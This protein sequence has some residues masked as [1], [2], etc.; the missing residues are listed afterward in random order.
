[1][2]GQSIVHRASQFGGF[3]AGSEAFNWLPPL[4]GGFDASCENNNQFNW[5]L[6]LNKKKKLLYCHDKLYYDNEN[7][8]TIQNF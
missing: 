7:K 8:K 4:F 1:M 6:I 2:V 5:H 3:L